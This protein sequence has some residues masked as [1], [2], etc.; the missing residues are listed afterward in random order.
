MVRVHPRGGLVIIGHQLRVKV[1]YFFEPHI[2]RV[3]MIN[4]CV[5]AD[6]NVLIV[7]NYDINFLSEAA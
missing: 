3:L 7:G 4:L 6:R 5:Q 2:L 1:E